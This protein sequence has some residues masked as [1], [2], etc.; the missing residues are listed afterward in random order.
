MESGRGATETGEP[1]Y[2]T[3]G[4]ST[5]ARRRSSTTPRHRRRRRSSI[6]L[7][8]SAG[9][10]AAAA[11][12]ATEGRGEGGETG[13]GAAAF[14]WGQALILVWGGRRGL[15]VGLRD[16]NFR[17]PGRAAVWVG[18][19]CDRCR[20]ERDIHAMRDDVA[21]ACRTAACPRARRLA[22]PRFCC[23]KWDAPDLPRF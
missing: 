5:D 16:A 2:S 12:A 14:R 21:H 15:G 3:R 11:A 13:E 6:A 19:T 23:L 20:Q 7:A 9:E 8:A 10:P 17:G 4:A 1:P 18:V 22:G